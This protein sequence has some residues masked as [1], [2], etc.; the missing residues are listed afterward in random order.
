MTGA[1]PAVGTLGGVDV[2]DALLDGPRARGVFLLR[3]VM[4]PPWALRIEDEAPLTL[5]AALRGSSW[6]CPDDGEPVELPEG[7]VVVIR[8]PDPYVAA[9]RPGREPEVVILP[10]GVCRSLRDG[11]PLAE[12][13]SQGVRTWG[14]PGGS[15]VLL[16]GSYEG[17]GEAS[18]PLLSALPRVAVRPAEADPDR[19]L[20]ALVEEMQVEAPGQRALLDRLFDAL[21]ISTLRAWFA[22]RADEAPGWFRAGRDP[23][24]GVAL[25]LLHRDV[26]HPWSVDELAARVGLSRAALARRFT[27]VLGEPPMSYLTSWRMA[28][29]ADRLRSSDATVAAVA[30]QVGYGTPFSF[31]AAFKR[32][33]GM[34]PQEYRRTPEPPPAGAVPVDGGS[35]RV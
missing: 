17:Q 10:G 13:W 16:V 3:T 4:E 9:D 26:A 20:A 15:T 25:E 31:S 29:A 6:L 14:T 19:I 22:A 27:Q 23:V 18:R 12:E 21:L 33:Y 11:R 35:A 30:R 5:V 34:S 7:H 1:A 28:L 24:V 32:V 8:G 2:L